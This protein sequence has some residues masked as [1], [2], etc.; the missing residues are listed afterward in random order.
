MTEY[1]TADRGLL[2]FKIYSL[3]M[4]EAQDKNSHNYHCGVQSI[5][6][7]CGSCIYNYSGCISFAKIMDRLK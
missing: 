2:K 3:Q 5:L 1:H 7:N 4:Y 6:D